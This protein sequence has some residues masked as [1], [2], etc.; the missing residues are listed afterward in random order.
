MASKPKTTKNPRKKT[1]KKWDGPKDPATEKGSGTYPNQHVKRTR[2]GHTITMDDSEDNEHIRIQHR[3]GS[4][5]IFHPDGAVSITTHKGQYNVVF[6]Q[7]RMT[8]TGA[9]DIT[10]K[11]D[12]SMRVYGDFNKTVH[13][14]YNMT[15]T[16]NH[17]AVVGGSYNK[18][19]NGN[20]DKTIG[21]DK[22]TKTRGSIVSAAKETNSVVGGS[23][24][25]IA[26]HKGTASVGAA[27]GI[28]LSTPENIIAKAKGDVGVDAGKKIDIASKDAMK[29]AS[30]STM[31]MTSQ[32]A[33]KVSSSAGYSV[34]ASGEIAKDGSQ[35]HLNSGKAQNADK[36]QVGDFAKATNSPSPTQVASS[37]DAHSKLA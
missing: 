6:G 34:K 2:S 30:Q 26:S 17:N 19:V 25:S 31:D 35:I 24:V 27:K 9:H 10:V 12:G 32:G 18:H 1:P 13:G 11:G 21:G 22:T 7:S 16:G 4:A 28:N 36:A 14:D 33:F 37:D 5:M 15:V 3:S 23:D 20:E 29:V 8:V